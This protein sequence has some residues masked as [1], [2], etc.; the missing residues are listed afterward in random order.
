MSKHELD[1]SLFHTQTPIAMETKAEI[2]ENLL[3]ESNIPFKRYYSSANNREVR[4]E[5]GKYIDNKQ[6][7]VIFEIETG[8]S[9]Y[10]FILYLLGKRLKQIDKLNSI[11][12]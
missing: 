5:H 12:L 6:K 11:W 4:S 1:L 8:D 10:S 9:Y 3:N 7:I 2:L